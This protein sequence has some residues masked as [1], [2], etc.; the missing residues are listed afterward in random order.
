MWGC[1][2]P[3]C[4][5][6]LLL[7]EDRI[8]GVV[9]TGTVHCNRCSFSKKSQAFCQEESQSFDP[10]IWT[11]AASRQ[12][13]LDFLSLNCLWVCLTHPFVLLNRLMTIF[14]QR[15]LKPLLLCVKK[16]WTEQLRREEIRKVWVRIMCVMWLWCVVACGNSVV[17]V[18]EREIFG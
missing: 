14:S 4:K 10:N 13:E 11:I 15:F 1:P 12:Q 18:Q 2:E 17:T 6:H 9:L 5:G 3:G 16:V 8:L 7:Q